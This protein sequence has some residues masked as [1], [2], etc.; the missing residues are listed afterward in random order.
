MPRTRRL[1]LLLTATAATALTLA[2]CAGDTPDEA[3][4]APAVATDAD[5]AADDAAAA[6]DATDDA[7]PED[8]AAAGDGAAQVS[9]VPAL[10]WEASTVLGDE[11]VVAADLAGQD[12]VLWIWAPWC[13]VCNNEA[14]EVARAL[15]DLP[16]DVTLI[17]VAGKDDV[18]PMREFVER[19]GL[20][21]VRHVVDEDG[22]LWASYGVSY[23]PAWVFIDDSGEASVVAGALGYDGLFAG[24]DETLRG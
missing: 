7:D 23:Q 4:D 20:E 10:W 22:S 5:D 17:G 18:G 2:G 12:V 16:E 19:H 15:A 14:P 13:T 1:A 9:A 8:G 24:I 11:R 21:S 6:V 3:A